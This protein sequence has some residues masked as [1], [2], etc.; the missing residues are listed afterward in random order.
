MRKA[1]ILPRIWQAKNEKNGQPMYKKVAK[2]MVVLMLM[3]A[4]LPLHAQVFIQDEEFEG[5]NRTGYEDFGLV[6]PYQG[7]DNDQYLPIGDGVL[8][9]T[10]LGGAYLM[11][12]LHKK[13]EA[14]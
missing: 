1:V 9:L 3:M 12:K 13:E 2:V 6:V 4:T 7:G 14:K 5:A 8:A 11:K 10:L